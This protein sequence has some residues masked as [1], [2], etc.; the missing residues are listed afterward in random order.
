VV[1]I[2]GLAPKSGGAV[3]L[4]TSQFLADLGDRVRFIPFSIDR[5]AGLGGRA[6]MNAANLWYLAVHLGSWLSALLRGRPAIAHYPVT[7]GWNFPKSMLFL[8]LARRLGARSIGHVH[9]GSID[10]YW[11]RLPGWQKSL[12]RRL[13]G[14]TDAMI[15]L[16]EGWRRWAETQ[17]EL[18]PPRVHVVFNPIEA[19]FEEAALTLE[20]APNE[21]ALFLGSIGK[22]KGVHDIL[23]LAA[24][25]RD[26]GTRI[27]MSLVGPPEWTGE[28]DALEAR[29]KSERLTDVTL[30]PP[31][32]G[33]AKLAAFRDH[34]IFL[35]PS[36]RENLP[37]VV[38]EAAAA[39]RAIVTTRV[40]GVP[41]FFS[42]DESVLFVEP[43]N[44]REMRDALRRLHGDPELRRRLGRAARAV[45]RTRLVRS[46]IMESLLRVYRT[47]LAGRETPEGRGDAGSVS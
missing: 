45:F 17:W 14:K 27:C 1:L 35:F 19:W 39:G 18:P 38:L 29:I 22:R 21:R 47:V 10:V 30:Q 43:G 7:S 40:G 8:W 32:S 41:E 24:L 13:I 20:P 2:G 44:I 26:E 36:Y 31:V 9:G 12:Y 5:T 25:L 34:G 28:I 16:S 11:E 33:Q 15:V 4:V 6:H 37:L 42:H 23:S 46:S 3:H